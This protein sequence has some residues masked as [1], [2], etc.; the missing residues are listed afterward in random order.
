MAVAAAR[1]AV[2]AAG[3]AACASV[4]AARAGPPPAPPGPGWLVAAWMRNAPRLRPTMADSTGCLS[5]SGGR[6]AISGPRPGGAAAG[7]LGEQ[8]PDPG[9]VVLVAAQRVP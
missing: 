9:G 1:L 8:R 6:R 5:R 3:W 4:T 2:R 7:Q